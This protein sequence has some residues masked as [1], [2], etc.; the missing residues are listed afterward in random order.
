M[1]NSKGSFRKEIK[2]LASERK[3]RRERNE[4]GLGREYREADVIECGWPCIG[5]VD[6]ISRGR[7]EEAVKRQ[8]KYAESRDRIMLK[9]EE[10]IVERSELLQMYR[11]KIA[12]PPRPVSEIEVM[13]LKEMKRELSRLGLDFVTVMKKR[14]VRKEK[15]DRRDLNETVHQRNQRLRRDELARTRRA[16][17]KELAARLLDLAPVLQETALRGM[18]SR[19]TITLTVAYNPVPFLEA[20]HLKVQELLDGLRGKESRNVGGDTESFLKKKREDIE[21]IEEDNNPK[22]S[23]TK[24]LHKHI[25]NSYCFHTVCTNEDIMKSETIRRTSVH[26]LQCI[27]DRFVNDVVG[28]KGVYPYEWMDGHDKFNER[29]LPPKENFYSGL[30]GEDISDENY[31]RAKKV[32]KV[33]GMKSMLDYHNLYLVTDMLILSDVIESFR[34][35]SR[36]TYGLDP[37]WYFTSPGLSWDACLKMS[38]IVL[39]LITDE[40]MYKHIEGGICGGVS[41]A[42]MRYGVADNKYVGISDI[43]KGVIELLKELDLQIRNDPTDIDGKVL[44]FENRLCKLLWNYSQEEDDKIM[45]YVSKNL[46]RW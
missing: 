39:Q 22:A 1:S 32:W 3:K 7:P 33:F 27:S 26:E 11:K 37:P 13:T 17:K 42:V 46:T 14:R 29:R 23:G 35:Q 2:S 19:Y 21:R 28:K 12:E 9:L 16:K 31:E 40:I 30:T 5:Y 4:R 43:P 18:V 38:R 44:E 10:A 15:I 36:K 24:E 20:V 45:T 34:K 6:D 25:M 41:T 8:R